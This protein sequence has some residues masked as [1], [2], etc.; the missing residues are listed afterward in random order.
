M[1]NSSLRPSFNNRLPDEKLARLLPALSLLAEDISEKI[2]LNRDS[3]AEILASVHIGREEWAF[4][5][6]GIW[7]KT[8]EKARDNSDGA[9]KDA[10]VAELKSR[11]IP[12]FPAILSIYVATSSQT[13]AARA[14]MVSPTASK[15]TTLVDKPVEPYHRQLPDHGWHND[16]SW[17]QLP[18]W[19]KKNAQLIARFR[20]GEQVVGKRVRYKMV[21]NKLIRRL[22]YRIPVAID[23]KGRRRHRR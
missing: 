6:L 8:L 11:G 14:D 13:E 16:I 18:D 12:E 9:Q 2:S 15:G 20:R 4:E 21:A 5:E 7:S 1:E 3:L 19:I 22:R 23:H 10:L 17:E